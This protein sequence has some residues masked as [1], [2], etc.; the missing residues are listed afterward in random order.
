MSEASPFSLP[1]MSDAIASLV[2]RHA[3]TV[4]AVHT[5]R[6]RAS[7]FAWRPGLVVTADESLADDE[8]VEVAFG[9][10]TTAAATIAGRDPTTDVALLR[11]VH[12]SM[13]ALVASPVP[14]AVGAFA[15][16]LGSHE[17]A[18]VAACGIVS[19]SSAAWR[20]LRGGDIDARIELDAGIRRSSEGGIAIDATG[21][22]IGMVVLGPR[23]RSLVIPMATIDR[24]ATRLDAHGRIAR[25]YLGAGLQR[26]RLD[27]GSPGAM[28]MSVDAAGPAARAGIHQGDVIATWDG[29]PVGGAHALHRRLGPDIVGRDVRLGLRRG[30]QSI[31]AVVT[32]AERPAS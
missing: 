23:R 14:V 30:G 27:D 6:S 15:I 8:P 1:A 4:V 12:A 11:V 10:G 19:V 28:V 5:R 9:D 13:T 26:V 21:Q 18:L 2:A 16:S 7:G 17:G 31:E 29:E 22:G 3:S 24:V 20:S 32:I 25:G